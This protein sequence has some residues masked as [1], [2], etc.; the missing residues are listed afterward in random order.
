[1]TILEF[2]NRF[3]EEKECKSYYR[4][5]REQEGITCKRCEGQKHYWLINR[6]VFECSHCKFRTSLRSG[7]VMENSRLP[8][9]TWFLIM[10]FMTST[11]KGI[12]ACEMQR[13]VGHQ[14]YATIWDIMHRLRKSMGQRDDLYMLEGMIEFDEGCFRTVPTT[15]SKRQSKRGRGS[16][17]QTNVAVMAE[18][19]PLEDIETSKKNSQCRYFKLKALSSY[20]SE[21]VDQVVK[22]SINKDSVLFTDKSTS[23]LNLSKYVDLHISEK[24]TKETTNGMLKWVHIAISNAKRNLLGIY[25]SVKETYLQSYLDEFCYKLNRRGLKSIFERLIVA[26]VNIPLQTTE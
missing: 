3:S 10:L 8:F 16:H 15:K 5:I 6:E 12:S 19:T 20:E 2:I 1:M 14:R 13:Q 9:K 7:T 23:Y 21:E 18:S 17:Q 24:S 26:S 4:Q 22:T 11:K 25:H